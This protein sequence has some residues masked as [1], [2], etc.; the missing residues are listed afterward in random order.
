MT[1]LIMSKWYLIALLKKIKKEQLN[2]IFADE[3]Q[4]LYHNICSEYLVQ[5]NSELRN[6]L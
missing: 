4:D 3:T 1:I 6:N 2:S 5:L